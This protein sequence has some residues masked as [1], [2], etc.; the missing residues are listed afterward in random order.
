MYRLFFL[1][2]FLIIR[3]PVS[4]AQRGEDATHLAILSR[5][6]EVESRELYDYCSKS[7]NNSRLE[8]AALKHFFNFASDAR[9]FSIS[10]TPQNYLALKK[11]IAKSS[12]S[13]MQLTCSSTHVDTFTYI[14]EVYL[15]I[16]EIM[17]LSLVDHSGLSSDS[18]L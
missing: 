2:L 6:L 7:S 18:S 1:L 16:K 11:S 9:K 8:R 5:S 4:F 10:L 3:G 13:W 12:G 15:Q 14:T 17:E